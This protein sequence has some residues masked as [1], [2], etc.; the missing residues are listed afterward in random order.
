MSRCII[1]GTWLED[2]PHLSES[3]RADLIGSYQ[4]YQVDARTKGVPQLG[5]GA[6][7]PF[8][9]SDIEI[10]DFKIPP[11]Y[12]C[13]FGLDCARAG[14][15]AAIWGALD[16][17]SDVL[18]LY[19]VYRRQQA[20]LAVHAQALLSRGKWI[21]GVG[22]AADILDED[23]VRFIDK[24]RSDFGIDLQLPDKAVE[25]GIQAVYDRMSSGRLKVFSSLAAFWEEFQMYRRDEK[26]RVVKDR[27]HVMD[28]CVSPD[29]LVLTDHGQVPIVD[30][31]GTTGK[32]WTRNNLLAPY[33]QCAL[34]REDAEL[35]KVTFDTGYE[36]RCTA[37]HRFLTPSGWKP[38]ERLAYDLVQMAGPNVSLRYRLV[39]NV[40]PAGRSDVYCLTVP[41]T[42]AFCLGNGAIVHNCRYLVLSGLARAKSQQ[43]TKPELGKN[44]MYSDGPDRGAWMG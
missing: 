1:G 22:D 44:L 15:T 30:L 37:D 12:R 38:A 21:K 3:A 6:V 43:G 2:S 27:D 4:K 32:V 13:A 11:H 33:S 14:T 7:Y 19:S 29:A 9:R 8:A 16:P 23:R 35:V 36:V 24:F 31:V 10:A 41:E 28:A 42:E 5:S 40:T 39:L 26:G 20:E 18:Y 17:D 25:T 34:T